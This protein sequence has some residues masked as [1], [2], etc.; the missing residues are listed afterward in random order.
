VIWVLAY[1]AIGAVLSLHAPRH[2]DDRILTILLWPVL[3]LSMV[4]VWIHEFR[5]S[6]E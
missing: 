3:L 2:L 6:P 1:L 4:V 5:R